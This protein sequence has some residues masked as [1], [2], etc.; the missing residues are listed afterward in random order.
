[1]LFSLLNLSVIGLSVQ[2]TIIDVAPIFFLLF[3]WQDYDTLFTVCNIEFLLCNFHGLR[4]SAY[5]FCFIVNLN[6]LQAYLYGYL[7]FTIVF[8]LAIFSLPDLKERIKAGRAKQ[9]V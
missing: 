4:V 7:L 2:L 8:D 5:C 6:L 9:T 3:S 1:M